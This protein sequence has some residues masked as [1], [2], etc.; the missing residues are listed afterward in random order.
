MSLEE[1]FAPIEILNR[2]AVMWD[3]WGHLA[4]EP[5]KRYYGYIIV[6]V[7][8]N[9]NHPVFDYEFENLG[10]G[11]WLYEDIV[12]FSFEQTK[13]LEG[14]ALYR[15]DGWYKKFKNGNCQFGGG[16]FEKLTI[17]REGGWSI[18][19]NKEDK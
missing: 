2:A 7:T 19:Y 17:I 16:K 15:W 8:F 10:G 6:A 12:M 5:H 18:M 11:P 9:N 13:Q 1:A 3:T 4:P 14:P